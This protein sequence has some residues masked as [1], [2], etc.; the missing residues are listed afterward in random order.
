MVYITEKSNYCMLR[1][2]RCSTFADSLRYGIASKCPDTTKIYEC[3]NRNMVRK[4]YRN[5]RTH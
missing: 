5:I 2:H 1:N 3:R 4:L